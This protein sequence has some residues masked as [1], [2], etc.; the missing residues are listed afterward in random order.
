M[1]DWRARHV[2]KMP[3]EKWEDNGGERGGEKG[4]VR[5]RSGRVR[6]SHGIAEGRSMLVMANG[7]VAVVCAGA[8]SALTTTERLRCAGTDR[9][10][11]RGLISF[12]AGWNIPLVVCDPIETDFG[13]G[14]SGELVAVQEVAAWAA[15][16]EVRR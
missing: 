6:A 9:G 3:L 11:S 14:E 5:C 12:D 13:C 1:R 2:E 10:R 16:D 8:G 7:G 15:A 4:G